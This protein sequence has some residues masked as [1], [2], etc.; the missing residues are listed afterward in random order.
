MARVQ[1]N[2]GELDQNYQIE[3][4]VRTTLR[5]DS[6]AAISRCIIVDS[7]DLFNYDGKIIAGTLEAKCNQI[8]EDTASTYSIGDE[9]VVF[10]ARNAKH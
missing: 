7:Y 2:P 5:T 1:F 9:N 4:S 10:F 3:D 8:A 6:R